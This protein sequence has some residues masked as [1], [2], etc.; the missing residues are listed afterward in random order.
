VLAHGGSYEK[1]NQPYIQS[2]LQTNVD[3]AEILRPD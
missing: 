3:V 2:Q 1:N